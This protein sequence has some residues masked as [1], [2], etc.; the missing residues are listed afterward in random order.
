MILFSK[1]LEEPG[2]RLSLSSSASPYYPAPSPSPP[3]P[4]SSS[5]TFSLYREAL[6]KAEENDRSLMEK[7]TLP[8]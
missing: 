7:S 4:T 2:V 6:G 8:E 1:I 3:S 5:L